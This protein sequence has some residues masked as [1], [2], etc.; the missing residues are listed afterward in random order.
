MTFASHPSIYHLPGTWEKQPLIH[1]GHLDP[2]VTSPIVLLFFA[3]LF[4]GIGYV[5]SKHT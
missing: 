5:L 2:I 1:H 4:L 3:I